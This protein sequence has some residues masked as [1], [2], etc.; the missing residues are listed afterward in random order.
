MSYI[1]DALKKAEAERERGG[2][3][4]LHTRQIT[5]GPPLQEPTKSSRL[6]IVLSIGL[7]LALVGGVWWKGRAPDAGVALLPVPAVQPA[8]PTPLAATPAPTVPVPDVVAPLPPIARPESRTP[9]KPPDTASSSAKSLAPAS[10]PA[11]PAVPAPLLSDLP[12]EVRGQIPTL[13]VSGNVYS[14]NPS[15]RLLLINGQVLSQGSN[16]A[17]DV[18]LVEIQRGSSEFSFRGTRFRVVH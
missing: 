11:A 16:V 8:A 5:P 3:P 14:D 4:G 6:G 10:A 17:P 15:Q 12:I 2:V 18:T 1:L 9:V 13:A 7:V